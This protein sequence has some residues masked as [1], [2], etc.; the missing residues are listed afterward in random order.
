VN[1]EGTPRIRRIDGV[2][3]R[4]IAGETVLVPIRRSLDQKVSV[5]T[6]NEVGSCIWGALRQP[7]SLGELADLVTAEFEV[8]VQQVQG[9]LRAFVGRLR[10]LHLVQEI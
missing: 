4:S 6:L 5:L 1:D 2:A 9:D 8:D 10:E 7:R 3:E